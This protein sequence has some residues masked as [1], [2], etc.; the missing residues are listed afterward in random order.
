MET[1]QEK[2]IQ[3]HLVELLDKLNETVSLSD[4]SM[5]LSGLREEVE[6]ALK[7]IDGGTFGVCEIC[8]ETIEEEYLQKDPL[9]KICFTHLSE[10]QKTAIEKDLELAYK[11]QYNLLP[12]S[13]AQLQ[14]WDIGYH[15]EPMG[16]LSGDFYDLINSKEK[17]GELFFLFGDISGKGISA[18][19]LMS[20]LSAIFRTLAAAN[21]PLKNLIETANRLFCDST[22]PSHFATLVCG[23]G[24]KTGE[25]EL[26]NAG[27]CRPLLSRSKEV[28]PIDSTGLPVGIHYSGVYEVDK[29][30]LDGGD[31]LLLYT[32]GLS[33]TRNPSGTEYGE[34]RLSEFLSS[35]RKLTAGELVKKILAD[36]NGF[37]AGVPITD[38]TTIMVIRRN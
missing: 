19:M 7:R 33:E 12:G 32:D 13:H 5:H 9:V 30:K 35:H 29:F 6:A 17:P 14:E 24:N 10:Q 36:V 11:I 4:S 3:N 31:T 23:R 2:T 38:D 27:H 37:R 1:S 28:T 18:A 20:N 25:I 15:Y 26:C 22:L 21:M 8:N 34:D 16:P